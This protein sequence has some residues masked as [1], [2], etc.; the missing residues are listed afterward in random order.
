MYHRVAAESSIVTSLLGELEAHSPAA[1]TR[2]SS[3]SWEEVW[4][5]F[6]KYLSH[7]EPIWVIFGVIEDDMEWFLSFVRSYGH[8]VAQL[9]FKSM[10]L[11]P[12]HAH[13]HWREE[14]EKRPFLR[15]Q[16]DACNQNDTMTCQLK[17][18]GILHWPCFFLQRISLLLS[19]SSEPLYRPA[20]C[21][22]PISSQL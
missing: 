20:L 4:L 8:S 10:Q 14:I 7:I 12:I 2:R 13:H 21:P 17:Y 18:K 5:V 15:G 22:Q 3:H 11:S 6:A 19:P 9:N 1:S 16:G